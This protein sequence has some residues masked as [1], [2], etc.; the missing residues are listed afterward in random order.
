[1]ARVVVRCNRD[2]LYRYTSVC[3]NHN[4]PALLEDELPPY[5]PPSN[6]QKSL[7]QELVPLRNL[8][9][10]DV[11]TMLKS[12]FPERPL[13]LTQV[14]NLLDAA[15]RAKRNRVQDIGGDMVA[16]VTLLLQKKQEDGRWVVHVEVDAETS[17][18]R[19]LFWMSPSQVGLA[20]RFGDVIVND[21]T[22]MRNQ[23]N[24]PLNVWVVIDQQ[25]KSRNIAYAL[26]TSE[27]IEDHR[28][29]LDHLFSILPPHP[30]RVYFSDADL[31]LDNVLSTKDVW[32]GLCLHHLSGNIAKNLAPVLGVLFQ[33]FLTAFWQVY[34]AVSPAAFERRWQK[35]LED[36]PR[37]RDY[38][39]RVLYPTRERWGWP[40][41][42]GR[43]TCAVRTSGRVESEH[44]VNKSF[45]NTKTSFFDLVKSLIERSDSQAED[46][47]L[48]AIKVSHFFA[49]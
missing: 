44:R 32:H 27:T 39:Q 33:P 29:V 28:W 2:G 34:H 24:V 21:V 15:K 40:W 20:H 14:S 43:F 1:M 38:L 23:Y 16:M 36:F 31:A 26:H 4:H 3:L 49:Y 7:V 45:G 6:E 9:R 41:V 13:T 25:F 8:T 19:R 18:F 11:H 46:E 37:S 5:F 30:S 48:S 47:R 22:L 17:R 35:L 10:R 12:R 42:A